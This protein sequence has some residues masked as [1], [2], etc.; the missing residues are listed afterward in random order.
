MVK[1][2]IKS[3]HIKTGLLV[4][5]L[6]KMILCFIVVPA[7]VRDEIWAYINSQN[8]NFSVASS[9]TGLY[10][11]VFN[12]NKIVASAFTANGYRLASLSSEWKPINATDTLKDLYVSNPFQKNSNTFLES[13]QQR[14][15]VIDKYP[16]ASGIFNFHSYNPY[17]SDPD[18]SFILY[19]QNVI[20]TIQSQLYYTYNRDENFSR[21]GYSGIYGGWY[22]Q[23]FVDVNETFNRSSRLSADTI[24]HWN[25][26][27]LSAGLQLPLNFTGGKMYRNLTTSASYNY[28]NVQW[29]GFAKQLLINTGFSYAQIRLRYSQYTQ[30]PVQYI[31]PHFGQS[32]LLQYRAG[33]SAHQFLVNGNFYFPGFAKTHSTVIN[34]A[35]QSRDTTNKYYFD[36]DFPFSRGYVTVNYPRLVKAAINYNF[37]LAYP[38][39][40]FGNIA[41]FLRIRANLFYDFTQAK[42]LRTGNQYNFTSAGTEIFFDTKWW[43]QQFISFGIRYSRL[44]NP[45]LTGQS[46]NQWEIVLPVNL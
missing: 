3:F 39:W 27:K 18:Y 43:N 22:L 23:P 15:L 14:N 41:Y 16:K 35:Y 5:R 11:G 37:P 25:E 34:L 8:K 29:T 31:N 40:G 38:D 42:S 30:Q 1:I 7:M 10:Q 4:S 19:G 13:I 45:D 2:S 24:L 33:S 21:I 6:Y 17:I 28:S 44:L 46:P 32:I 9:A 36:N 12:D 26:T 20:N